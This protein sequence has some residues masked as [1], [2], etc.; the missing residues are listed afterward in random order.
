MPFLALKAQLH[1][2]QQRAA[3]FESLE[4]EVPGSALKTELIG[5]QRLQHARN[6]GG[7]LRQ[8]S[9]PTVSICDKVRVG[10]VFKHL[11][12]SLRLVWVSAMLTPT[13]LPTGDSLCAGDEVGFTPQLPPS[14]HTMWF[15]VVFKHFS[16][17][18]LQA[19]CK[20]QC[21]S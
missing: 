9:S 20:H 3:G 7:H 17:H 11:L 2:S 13:R 1:G 15:S 6:K 10:L 19:L 14:C 21:V 18:S 8:L 5:N 12:W 16:F 4:L